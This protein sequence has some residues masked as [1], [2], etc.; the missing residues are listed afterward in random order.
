MRTQALV[1]DNQFLRAMIPHHSGAILICGSAITD[2]QIKQLCAGIL[3]SQ[4]AEIA[5]MMALLER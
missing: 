2:P 1:G 3:A 4:K 5:Q